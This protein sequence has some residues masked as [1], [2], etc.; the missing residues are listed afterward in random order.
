MI[1]YMEQV[2]VEGGLFLDYIEI[3]RNRKNKYFLKVKLIKPVLAYGN[4]TQLNKKTFIYYYYVIY[5]RVINI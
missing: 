2:V 5:E 1:Q 3:V 4:Q